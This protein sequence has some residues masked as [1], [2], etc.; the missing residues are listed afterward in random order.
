MIK[1]RQ[2]SDF[3]IF[4]K[5]IRSI[6]TFFQYVLRCQIKNRE[7]YSDKTKHFQLGINILFLD[8]FSKSDTAPKYIYISPSWYD[9]SGPLGILKLI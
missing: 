1:I 8:R 9:I 6:P 2:F 3:G 5:K 4:I 7:I